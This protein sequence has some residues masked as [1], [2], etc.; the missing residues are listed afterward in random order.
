MI[1][2]VIVVVVLYVTAGKNSG[3]RFTDSTAIDSSSYVIS[4]HCC[5]RL[6]CPRSVCV[7]L[8]L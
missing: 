2:I 5:R 4:I 8:Y 7:C 1:I 3:Q 6:L